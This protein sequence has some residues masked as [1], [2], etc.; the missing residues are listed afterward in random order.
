C[1]AGDSTHGDVADADVL[2]N[3][4]APARG[5]HA[6][7]GLYAVVTA[8]LHE[9][10][11]HS[12]GHVAADGDAAVPAGCANA[13]DDDI[14]GRSPDAPAVFVHTRLERNAIVA[15]AKLAILNDHI[16]T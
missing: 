7:A 10:I 1:I 11:S 3:A 14:F 12:A 8:I 13:P 9:H 16:A 5:L 6:D 4:A 2:D 15:G